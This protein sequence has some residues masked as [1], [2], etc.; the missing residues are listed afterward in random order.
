MIFI[1][2]NAMYFFVKF[3][4]LQNLKNVKIFDKMYFFMKFEMALMIRLEDLQFSYGSISTINLSSSSRMFSKWI[5]AALEDA[6]VGL[7]NVII[8]T[9]WGIEVIWELRNLRN[10]P[11]EF[12]KSLSEIVLIVTVNSLESKWFTRLRRKQ[13]MIFKLKKY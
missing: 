11:H 13:K 8:M 9:T 10:Q 12:P 6:M 5:V 1:F 7:L 4:S 2:R 3:P